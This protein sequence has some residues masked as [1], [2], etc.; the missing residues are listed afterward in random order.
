MSNDD[1]LVDAVKARLASAREQRPMFRGDVGAGGNEQVEPY[2][3]ELGDLD[4]IAHRHYVKGE[5]SGYE[6]GWREGHDAGEAHGQRVRATVDHELLTAIISAV[7]ERLD[8]AVSQFEEPMEG[9]RDRRDKAE[10]RKQGL[11]LI[12]SLRASL[13]ILLVQVSRGEFNQG[14]S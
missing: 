12:D 10:L 4:A 2:R 6:R 14:E 5:R 11:A 13:S 7:T 8:R 9:E 1:L 3:L